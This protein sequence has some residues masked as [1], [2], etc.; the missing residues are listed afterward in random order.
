MSASAADEGSGTRS[1]PITSNANTSARLDVDDHARRKVGG[2]H[3][4][5]I[6]RLGPVAG[7]VA[8]AALRAGREW[9]LLARIDRCR[10][11]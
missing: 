10:I 4:D 8:I 1:Q 11:Q 2:H 7:L 6:H 3:A 5:D 9:Q